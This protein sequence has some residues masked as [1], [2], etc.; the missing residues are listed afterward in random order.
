MSLGAPRATTLRLVLGEGARIA[1][2]LRHRRAAMAADVG[3]RPH[4]QSVD[5]FQR[6]GKHISIAETDHL[7]TDI[8]AARGEDLAEVSDAR[9]RT[10]RFNQ[11]SDQLDHLA[12]PDERIDLA[13]PGKVRFEI[14]IRRGDHHG[15]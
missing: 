6:H 14:D 5:F 4:L 10:A 2:T 9:C 3:E 11:Q 15:R 7:R 1:A 8:P 12:R 13:Q